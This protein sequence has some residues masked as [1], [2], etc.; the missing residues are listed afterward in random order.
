MRFVTLI[1]PILATVGS[2]LQPASGTESCSAE[3]AGCGDCASWQAWGEYDLWW[4]REGRT[5]P[6]LTSGGNGILGSPGTQVVV[7][8]LENPLWHGG[9]FGLG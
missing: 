5:W 4:L 1:A 3:V 2:S 8:S 6:L 7:D 9:R